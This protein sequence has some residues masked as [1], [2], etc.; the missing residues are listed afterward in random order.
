MLRESRENITHIASACGFSN[1]SYFTE[2]FVKLMKCTPRD[3]R[4]KANAQEEN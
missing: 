2:T 4:S 3:Y 1:S